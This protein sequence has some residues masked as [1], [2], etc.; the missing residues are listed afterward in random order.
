MGSIKYLKYLNEHVDDLHGKTI[1][2]TGANSGIGFYAARSLAF[3]GARIVM[4]CRSKQRAEDARKAILDVAPKADID[5]MHLDQASFDSI[6]A[7]AI[8]L[9]EKYSIINAF[10]F[11][12]G[13]FHPKKDALTNDGYPLTMGTNYLGTYFLLELLNPYFSTMKDINVVCVGSLANHRYKYEKFDYYFT[14]PKPTLFRQ[15]ALSKE[16]M[17]AN[18]HSFMAKEDSNVHYSLMHPGVASTN[19]VSSTS[20]SFPTW[21]S[22]IARG[23]MNAFTN[24][25]E[26]SALGIILLASGKNT[27][28]VYL[29]PRGLFGISGYPTRKK[30]PVRLIRNA[31]IVHDRTR[32]FFVKIGRL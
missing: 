2:I 10:V 4:A 15:Y 18:H 32:E 12:A 3:K 11:N 29:Y 16:F 26:K 9:Q 1:V 20:N 6:K 17:M 19:I 7:F 5:I 25:P 8:S 22:R 31:A 27:H 30:V 14:S 24:H 28:R 21:F 23:F 13:I